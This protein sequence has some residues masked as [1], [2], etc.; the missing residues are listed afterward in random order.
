ME[1]GDFKEAL[2]NCLNRSLSIILNFGRPIITWRL[3]ISI[4][5]KR[6]GSELLHD[7]LKKNKGNI[8][9]LCNLAVFYYYEKKEE[10]LESLLELLVKIKPYQFEHRYKLGATFALIGRHKEAYNWLRS[11]QKGG[12][13]G[14]QAII[15]G[16]PILLIFL[17]MKKW[18]KKPMQRLSIWILQKLDYEPWKDVQ[19]DYSSL[20]HLNRIGN[21][22][23][24]K[25]EM[26]IEV[27]GC[28]VFIFWKIRA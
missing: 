10:E 18:R 8:H 26:N 1:S 13:K 21:F 24:G 6:T 20:T 28:S 17:D 11:L 15:S 9:A 5:E 7:V 22:Y 23:W 27:K 25:S 12:L 16:C 19:E 3:P 4:S 2:W 14:I